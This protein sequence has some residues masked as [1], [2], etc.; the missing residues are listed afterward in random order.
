MYQIRQRDGCV[1]GGVFVLKNVKNVKECEENECW[2]CARWKQEL[3]SVVIEL[4]SVKEIVRILK[5]ELDSIGMEVRNSVGN[6]QSKNNV[7]DYSEDD[8]NLMNQKYAMKQRNFPRYIPV[9][10]VT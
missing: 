5:E 8:W 3:N 4:N 9:P 1:D 7:S 10:V 2:C 6:I